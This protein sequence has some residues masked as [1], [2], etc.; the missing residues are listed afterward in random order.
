MR[1]LPC[2]IQMI[3]NVSRKDI[4]TWV[5]TACICTIS[6]LLIIFKTSTWIR[7][8]KTLLKGWLMIVRRS[9]LYIQSLMLKGS[10]D[11]C[12]N[13]SLK[14]R[15]LLIQIR[16]NWLSLRRLQRWH[17]KKSKNMRC[18]S[19]MMTQVKKKTPKKKM[20]KRIKSLIHSKLLLLS[21]RRNER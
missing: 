14:I 6:V 12:K 20:K 21:W 4:P 17:S 15:G 7:K 9:R 8:V 18:Q 16:R 5:M 10:S 1:T 11:L 19:L 2:T 3:S 13:Q